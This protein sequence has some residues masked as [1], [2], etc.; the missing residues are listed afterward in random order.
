MRLRRQAAKASLATPRL[1]C[2]RV[3]FVPIAEVVDQD[4]T[5]QDNSNA[6]EKNTNK[7]DEDDDKEDKDDKLTMPRDPILLAIGKE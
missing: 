7:F 2:S 3:N 4:D 6:V 5:S 1:T